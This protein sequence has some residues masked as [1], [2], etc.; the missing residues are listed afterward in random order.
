MYDH[1][2]ASREG[3]CR[4]IPVLAGKL[5]AL[6]RHRELVRGNWTFR[7]R[8]APGMPPIIAVLKRHQILPASTRDREVSRRIWYRHYCL[9]ILACAP[10]STL[11][12]E[13]I[14]EVADTGCTYRQEQPA[15]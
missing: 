11:Y 2:G 15:P 12:S 13:G 9:Q 7:C 8:R 3:G 1:A 5:C 6:R 14:G 10:A 4:P